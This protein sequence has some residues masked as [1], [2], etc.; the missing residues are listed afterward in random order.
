MGRV[1]FWILSIFE[2]FLWDFIVKIF[3]AKAKENRI[4]LRRD[5]RFL[6]VG[7]DFNQDKSSLVPGLKSQFDNF[8]IYTDGAGEYS[9]RREGLDYKNV[10]TERFCELVDDYEIEVAMLQ[11]WTPYFDFKYIKSKYPHIILIGLSWDDALPELWLHHY[12]KSFW[13]VSRYFDTVLLSNSDYKRRYRYFVSDVRVIPMG[14]S[15]EHYVISERRQVYDIIF[16]GNNYGYRKRI[17]KILLSLEKEFNLTIRLYGRGMRDGY[18]DSDLIGI[19]YSKSRIVLGCGLVGNSYIRTTYKLRDMEALAS[20]AL[21]IT[22]SHND[23]VFDSK[24]TVP[25]YNSLS[26]LKKLILYYLT[27]V[28][29]RETLAFH[30]QARAKY[31]DWSNVFNKIL[32]K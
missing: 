10:N 2:F 13:Y 32:F 27:H 15:I 12:Y 11:S 17:V 9:F 18:L 23:F 14:Y 4:N 20:S 6:W 7:C 1:K 25:T 28:E 24:S 21:Y 8:F 30:Q 29:L 22:K 19:E 26:R 5:S 3:F 31:F 16:V